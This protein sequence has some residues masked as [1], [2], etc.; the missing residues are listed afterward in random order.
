MTDIANLIWPAWHATS[1]LEIISVGFGLAYVILAARENIFCWPAALVSTGTAIFLFWDASLVMESGLN[2]YYLL[3]ALY[4]WWQWRNGGDNGHSL[5]ISS[6]R[7]WHHVAAIG[8][9]G[10]LTLGS[11]LLL[12]TRTQAALPF[13]DSFTT[14]SAVIATI[15]M[16]WKILENWLYWVVIDIASIF[17]YIDRGL[18][19]Y[20]LLFSIYVIIALFGYAQWRHTWRLQNMDREQ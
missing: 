1:Q 4:G 20:A 2:I 5:S 16:A 10:A 17:L 8:L 15:M 12:N 6:W 9:V 7:F 18:H 11:G 3:M 14:W 19:L 13:L